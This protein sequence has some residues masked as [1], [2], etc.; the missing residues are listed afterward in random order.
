M[1]DKHEVGGS[2]PLGPTNFLARENRTS[3][4]LSDFRER[5][6]HLGQPAR[7]AVQPKGRT[8]LVRFLKYLNGFE[9]FKNLIKE[10]S[11]AKC[12]LKTE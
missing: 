2:S 9:Y 5:G 3:G 6:S 12:S 1:P 8:K 4:V 11:S 10:L 7:K